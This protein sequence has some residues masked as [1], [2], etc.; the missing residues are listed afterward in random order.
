MP[1]D[2]LVEAD[3]VSFAVVG[4]C[5]WSTKFP[6]IKPLGLDVAPSVFHH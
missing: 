2:T 3:A 4:L 5:S 1:F 6:V